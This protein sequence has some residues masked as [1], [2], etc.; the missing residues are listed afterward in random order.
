MNDEIFFAGDWDGTNRRLHPR[1]LAASQ[2]Y[3][4]RTIPVLPVL[5]AAT[6]VNLNFYGACISVADSIVLNPGDE[7]R[8]TFAINLPNLNL[9]KLHYRRGRVAWSQ[10]GKIGVQFFFDNEGKPVP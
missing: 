6:T 1:N 5:L 3:L 8:V 9:V 10:D 2:V 7:V 4:R